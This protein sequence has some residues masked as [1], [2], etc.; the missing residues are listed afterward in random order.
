MQDPDYGNLGDHTEAVQIDYDP[1]QI[2]YAHLLRIFWKSHRPGQR[3][4][5]RQYMNAVFHHDQDQRQAGLS[6][7]AAIEE[8]TGRTVHTRVLPLQAFY[9]AEDYHQKYLLNRNNALAKELLRIYPLQ[10]D[11]TDSTAVARINGYVGGYGLPEQ[12]ERELPDLGLSPQSRENLRRLVSGKARRF[13][14]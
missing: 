4:W 5:K 7:K 6:S 11:F 8:E 3:A 9:R 2:T 12:L 14:N 1:Q 10:K 13:L